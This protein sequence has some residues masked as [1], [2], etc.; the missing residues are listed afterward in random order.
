MDI[1]RII[2]QVTEQVM[3]DMELQEQA[4]KYD[5]IPLESVSKRF[6]HSLLDPAISLE[7][8]VKGC[9][10][11]RQYQLGNICV[12]PYFVP[13]AAEQLRNT[14]IAVCAPVGFPQAHASTAAKI[15]EIKECIQNGATELDVSLNMAAIKSGRYDDARRDLDL[16]LAACGNRAMFKAI[17]EQA[18]YTENEKE[19]VLTMIKNSGA[20]GLKISNFFTGKKAAEEDVIFVRSIVGNSLVIKIDGGVKTLEKAMSLFNSGAT[21]I[22]LT[23]AVKICDEAKAAMRK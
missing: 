19:K 10:E 23:A 18:A 21:R 14:G 15:A 4:K 16:M 8:I 11:A 7:K 22:G 2:A 5:A 1:D 12:N 3:R 13:F 9:Y 6:E 17:Y 20:D